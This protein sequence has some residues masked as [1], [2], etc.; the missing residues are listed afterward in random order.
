[1]ENNNNKISL[2]SFNNKKLPENFH[3][4]IVEL[5]NKHQK[6]TLIGGFNDIKVIEDLAKL[7]KIGVEYYNNKSKI[8][9]N[10]FYE[11][12][13]KL[14]SN[15]KVIKLMDENNNKDF[16]IKRSFSF[17]KQKKF[18]NIYSA[19]F[20][21][22]M[23]KI[24]MSQSEMPLNPFDLKEEKDHYEKGV[25]IINDNLSN[26]ENN[27]RLKL[28]KAKKE[29]KEKKRFSSILSTIS[30]TKGDN[31]LFDSIG[32]N[33]NSS[34]PRKNINGYRNS[35]LITRNFSLLSSGK[36]SLEKYDDYSNAKEIEDFDLSFTSNNNNNN[37]KDSKKD[38][39]NSSNYSYITKRN[40]SLNLFIDKFLIWLFNKYY[41]KFGNEIT[42]NFLKLMEETYDNKKEIYLEYEEDFKSF[43]GFLSKDNKYDESIQNIIDSL[44]L[45][46][47]EKTQFENIK[48]YEKIKGVIKQERNK[49]ILNEDEF[50]ENIDDLTNKIMKIVV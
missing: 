41:K 49:E 3:K 48:L 17:R 38:L 14:L 2:E 7:Y 33:I 29:K 50:I 13:Q 22:R 11:K 28:E 34:S 16:D 18:K 40:K 37:N 39:K 10:Y 9:E 20:K 43:D 8:N 25:E 42:Q 4:N 15:E 44:V 24:L 26:Q 12:L 31:S 36:I 30:N 46:R 5:E 45:E 32:F 35:E 6:N 19:Q 1:M 21:I 23:N 47:N 27:F